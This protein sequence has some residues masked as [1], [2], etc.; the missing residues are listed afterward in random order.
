MTY[1]QTAPVSVHGTY[2]GAA[3][4]LSRAAA[5]GATLKGLKWL[6]H[7]TD[8]ILSYKSGKVQAL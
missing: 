3:A 2:L 5:C 8:Q 4:T 7:A 6:P 1:A